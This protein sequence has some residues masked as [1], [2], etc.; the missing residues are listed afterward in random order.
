[1]DLFN[2]NQ[3]TLHGG[4]SRDLGAEILVQKPVTSW[5]QVLARS[6]GFNQ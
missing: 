4:Q 2:P 6:I 3:E 1:M 5:I